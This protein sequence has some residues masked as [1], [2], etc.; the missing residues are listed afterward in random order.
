MSERRTI[1]QILIEL[2]RITDDD[3]ARALE[4]QRDSGGYFGEAL[5]ALGVVSQDELEW[6][7]ASQHDLPYV[8]PDADACD[9][10]VAALV[11][12][13]WALANLTLPIMRVGDTV[14]VIVDS[15]LKDEPIRELRERTGLDVDMALAAPA[16][17]REVIGEVFARLAAAD[18]EG[19]TPVALDV[20]LGDI[21]TNEA[22][23][24]GI[25]VRGARP[26]VWWE[27]PG[28]VRRRP[29]SAGWKSELERV[30]VPGP[31]EMMSNARRADWVADVGF[32]DQVVSV[33][34]H[35][36]ADESG[37]ELA[38]HRKEG[39]PELDTRFGVIPPELS[40]EIL[41]LAHGGD[42]RILVRSTSD[43]LARSITPHL[44]ALLLGATWRSV[45]LYAAGG[46]EHE[47]FSVRLQDGTGWAAEA[48]ALQAFRFD[49]AT[50][51]FTGASGDPALLRDVA[52]AVFVLGDASVAEPLDI[53]WTLDIDPGTD[54]DL[55][56][57]LG[58]LNG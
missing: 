36:L 49:A 22:P 33:D 40:A 19:A 32:D 4:H 25:S 56:W 45:Y 23:R 2:G 35:Y 10:D 53:R 6:G 12:A 24:F 8:F 54:G 16:S 14:Q 44:P 26:L 5:V 11:S 31:M 13:E 46:A 28:G 42:A 51:D 41:A 30:L 55:S 47:A 57:S 7:L 3:V 29:L 27:S 37:R 9:L 38:F 34:V 48:D 18:E 20:A 21:L 43:D 50:I 17:I 15:P 39:A 1:G 52:R 58:P